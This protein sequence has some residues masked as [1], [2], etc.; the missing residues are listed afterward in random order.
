M[1]SFFCYSLLLLRVLILG[2]IFNLQFWG[3]EIMRDMIVEAAFILLIFIHAIFLSSSSSIAICIVGQIG[4]WQPHF[5][6]DDLIL[7]NPKHFFHIFYN[8][9]VPRHKDRREKV[10]YSTES[11]LHYNTTYLAWLS[12]LNEVTEHVKQLMT[13]NN[14]KVASIKFSKALNTSTIKM[15][16][17]V[18]DKTELDRMNQR[19]YKNDEL[20]T[21]ILNM[22]LHQEECI[23]SLIEFEH[24]HGKSFDFIIS[25]REDI[26]LF[27]KLDID[28]FITLLNTPRKHAPPCDILFKNCLLWYGFNMRFYF[29]KR[30]TGVAYLGKRL[31]FYRVMKTINLTA[32]NPEQ[33]EKFQAGHLKFNGCPIPFDLVPVTAAR[34]VNH[35]EICFIDAELGCYNQM[36]ETFI[37]NHLCSKL[38]G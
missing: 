10:I 23:K 27:L 26:F 19:N 38:K 22:Y 30:D 11:H 1:D 29:M 24:I 36:N 3:C 20:Q 18:N 8:I 31:E 25:T 14:S 28:N 6:K 32:H 21:R 33:F 34:H 17:S 5:L 7:A 13:T 12:D 4:R 2:N 16:V 9:Q 37:Q 15:L 35:G